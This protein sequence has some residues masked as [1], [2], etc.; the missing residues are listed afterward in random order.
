MNDV[1]F[2][3]VDELRAEIKSNYE[4]QGLV[5]SG[6]FGNE[7]RTVGSGGS[8]K[9]VAPHYAVQMILG[10]RAGKRPPVA[11]IKQWIK[12]KNRR[13]GAGIPEEAAFAIAKKIG[14]DGIRVPNKFNNGTAIRSVVT[15][16]RVKRLVE[17]MKRVIRIQIL[18]ILK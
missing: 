17:D 12:D 14:E 1:I 13:T 5:A 8:I 18:N 16:D 6:R 7:L 2:K 10:R 4:K 9:I 3:L 15:P 11:A